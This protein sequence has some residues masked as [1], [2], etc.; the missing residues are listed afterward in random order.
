M[1]KPNK[2]YKARG[3]F[4]T[5]ADKSESRRP[6]LLEFLNPLSLPPSETD[7]GQVGPTWGDVVTP[8]P[9]NS[10]VNP[11]GLLE[12]LNPFSAPPNETPQAS[13]IGYTDPM[14]GVVHPDPYRNDLPHHVLPPAQMP[15][16]WQPPLSQDEIARRLLELR[17]RPSGQPPAYFRPAPNNYRLNPAPRR[18][19]RD[20]VT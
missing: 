4:K 13:S 16:G 18:N 2:P 9:A 17:Q 3:I 1:K 6:T 19:W 11:P 5:V 10:P 20:I 7:A 14:Q 12:F 15:P 8:P